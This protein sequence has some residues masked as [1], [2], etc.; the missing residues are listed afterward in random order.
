M[1]TADLRFHEAATA[2]EKLKYKSQSSDQILA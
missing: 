2:I 1:H